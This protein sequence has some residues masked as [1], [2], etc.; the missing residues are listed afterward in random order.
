MSSLKKSDPLEDDCIRLWT[1]MKA[2]NGAQRSDRSKH[3][4]PINGTLKTPSTFF[5]SVLDLLND[6]LKG[7]ISSGTLLLRHL[8]SIAEIDENNATRCYEESFPSFSHGITQNYPRSHQCQ[9]QNGT[10]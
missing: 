6:T 10:R 7:E 4:V 9:R 2:G 1:F 5:G 3:R 8:D